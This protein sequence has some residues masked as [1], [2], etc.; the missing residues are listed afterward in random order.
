MVVIGL[1]Q[2][3]CLSWCDCPNP[4]RL[5]P[6]EI[7]DVVSNDVRASRSCRQF[8]NKIVV[9]IGKEGPPCVKNL[10]RMSEFAQN[11]DNYPDLCRG[12]CGHKSR[13][14]GDGFILNRERHGEGN[15]DVSTANRLQNRKT[16]AKLGAKCRYQNTGVDDCVHSGIIDDTSIFARVISVEN[17][18]TRR[19]T[20]SPKNYFSSVIVTSS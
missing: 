18:A 4:Q 14:Q 7:I 1:Y 20:S 19:K 15:P 3:K 17:A 6:L 5:G 12:E 13:A 16:R 8:D 9:R 10:L 11:I 2:V